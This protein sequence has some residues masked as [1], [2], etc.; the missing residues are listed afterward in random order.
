MKDIVSIQGYLGSFHH[1][2]ALDVFGQN[3]QLLERDSFAEVFAD[4]DQG[5]ADYGVAAISNAVYGGI[6]DSQQQLKKY[7]PVVIKIV[8]LPIKQHLIG[9]PGSTL[10]QIKT[11][12]SHPVALQQCH[13]FL[14][15]HPHIQAIKTV[16]TA[17]SVADVMVAA[18][19]TKAAIAGE[20]AATLYGGKILVPDIHDRPDNHTTFIVFRKE[21]HSHAI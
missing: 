9:V 21:D 3:I 17:K 11:I 5:N 4:V 20:I 12:Y 13:L 1:R 16:D 14:K 18:D 10:D 6:E 8:V 7:Q 19:P 15:D 2:V